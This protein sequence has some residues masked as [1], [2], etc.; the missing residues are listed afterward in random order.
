MYQLSAETEK[1]LKKVSKGQKFLKL[2]I[3]VMIDNQTV[4]RTFGEN[5]EID[6]EDNIYEIGSVTK[7]FTASLLAKYVIENKMSLNDPINKYIQGL[8]PNKYY[9]SL[10]RIVT[11][12]SGYS[13]IYPLNNKENLKLT[14]SVLGIGKKTHGNNLIMDFNKMIE[15]MQKS[16]MKDKD[17][18]WAYS[19]FAI[20]L[21]GYAIGTASGRGYWEC[22]E[23]FLKNELGMKNSYLG[24]IKDKNLNG[25]NKKNE[26]CG[27]WEWSEGQELMAPAGAISST[28]EDILVFAKANMYEEKEYL[29]LC[30]KKYT[31]VGKMYDM[32]LGWILN[33]SNNNIIWHTG[34][35]GCFFSYLGIDKQKKIAVVI[36]KNYR[37]GLGLLENKIGPLILE[38]I[39][40]G[41]Q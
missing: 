22:M 36:L 17:Y 34:N 14:L 29:K 6:Y 38:E 23:N 33:K 25:F 37:H 30:H 7:T 1:L 21:L 4:F 40:K 31:N 39:G 3:G 26:N 19:N 9:P 27:N 35:T 32:G 11:H 16:E 8:E 13:Q 2:N 15:F 12:T 10:K 24:T 28:A 5:G 18:N 41:I 20:A